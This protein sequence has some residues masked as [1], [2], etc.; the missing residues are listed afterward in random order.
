M[1]IELEEG[2]EKIIDVGGLHIKASLKDGKEMLTIITTHNNDAL[3]VMPLFN[4]SITI[5]SGKNLAR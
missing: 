1:K 5:L 3:L 4:N 2:V